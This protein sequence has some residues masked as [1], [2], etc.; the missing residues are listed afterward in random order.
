M[1][2]V[3]EFDKILDQTLSTL[4]FKVDLNRFNGFE[5]NQYISLSTKINVLEE[6]FQKE[7]EWYQNLGLIK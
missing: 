1:N 6:Y 3:D 2:E 4:P 7:F 5:E